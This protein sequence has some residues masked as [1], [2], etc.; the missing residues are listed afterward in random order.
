MAKS[1][2]SIGG[3]GFRVTENVSQTGI[4]GNDRSHTRTTDYSPTGQRVSGTFTDHNGNQYGTNSLGKTK[5]PSNSN[6]GRNK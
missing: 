5:G 4:L 6:D 3:G 2:S 1:K